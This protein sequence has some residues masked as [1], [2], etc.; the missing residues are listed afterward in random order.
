MNDP[1]IATFAVSGAGVIAMIALK[2]YEHSTGKKSVLA[3]FGDSTNHIAR[4]A[5][6]T[7]RMYF[8]YINRRNAIL[9]AQFVLDHIVWIIRKLQ[10]RI[11]SHM[12]A[13]HSY[14][15][16]NVFSAIKG[17]G[18]IQK[19]GAVSFFL[20]QVREEKDRGSL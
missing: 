19:R 9:M 2:F 4:K 10:R 18:V 1:F 6:R 17:R 14:K 15:P 20:K 13:K 11:Q 5:Y 8:S 16:Y 3:R 7:L 12:E